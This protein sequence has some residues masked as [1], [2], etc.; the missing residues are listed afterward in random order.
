MAHSSK[1]AAR[2]DLR[3]SEVSRVAAPSRRAFAYTAELAAELAGF[4]TSSSPRQFESATAKSD[5]TRAKSPAPSPPGLKENDRGQVLGDRPVRRT[6]KAEA[7]DGIRMAVE[8]GSEGVVLAQLRAPPQLRIALLHH[9]LNVRPCAFCFTLRLSRPG[10]G[11]RAARR[12]RRGR[13][14]ELRR[15]IT[16]P[17]RR[18][19]GID[20]LERLAL[21]AVLARPPALLRGLEWTAALRSTP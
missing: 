18:E 9:L 12:A 3:P 1:A 14:S 11:A 19:P 17:S 16:R 7:I 5:E 20:R 6:A 8:E 21:D 2:R 10:T 13:V 15:R 4:T